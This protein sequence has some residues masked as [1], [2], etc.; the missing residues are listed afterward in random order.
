MVAIAAGQSADAVP[1]LA[2]ALRRIPI[3]ESFS[4]VQVQAL[5][6]DLRRIGAIA[7]EVAPLIRPFLQS[8]DASVRVSA[9]AALTQVAPEFLAE[10]LHVLVTTLSDPEAVIFGWDEAIAALVDLGPAARDTVP[11]LQAIVLDEEKRHLWDAN[12]LIAT[13]LKID[14]TAA[15]WM[16]TQAEAALLSQDRL[17]WGVNLL[18]EVAAHVPV[19]SAPILARL[20]KD[21]R[22]ESRYNDVLNALWGLGGQVKHAAPLLQELLQGATPE[23]AARIN[24]LLERSQD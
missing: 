23:I 9:A 19:R 1:V 16:I 22:A 8:E 13:L 21:R 7:I 12:V 18:C 10:A 20:L 5:L 6:G 14:A 17:D 15:D 4:E 24:T 11:Q 3:N 2:A